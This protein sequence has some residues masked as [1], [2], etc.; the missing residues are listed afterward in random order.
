VQKQRQ[1]ATN[2]ILHLTFSE[3]IKEHK[4]LGSWQGEGL[5]AIQEPT[6]CVGVAK[7]LDQ[8]QVIKTNV[9]V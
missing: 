7:R 8:I 3:A 9:F 5:V 1:L 2:I 6:L 4:S